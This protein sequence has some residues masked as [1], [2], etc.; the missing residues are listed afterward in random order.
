MFFDPISS[1]LAIGFLAAMYFLVRRSH[2]YWDR[3]GVKSV[4]PVFLLGNFKDNICQRK[5][6]SE[7]AADI[8]KNSTEPL[9]GVYTL[10]R[11]AVVLC[12]PELIRNVFSKDFKHFYHRGFH[13]DENVDPSALN[14]LVSN[15][16]RWKVLREKLSPTFA[17]GKLKGMFDVIAGCGSS[18]LFYVDEYADIDKPIEIREAFARYAT[19]IIASV[20]FGIDID[21]FQTKDAEF[22]ATGSR[23]F[24]TNWRNTMRQMVTTHSPRLSML[25]GIRFMDHEVQE[26]MK[27]IVSRNLEFRD[28]NNF[29]RKDFFQLLTN[30]Y[31]YGAVR[32]DDE[33]K[34]IKSAVDESSKPFSLDE[35]T[36][37]AVFVFAASFETTSST[38]SHC[39]YELSLHA[40][41]Q[42]KLHEEIDAAGDC[43]YESIENMKYLDC[44]VNGRHI[45]M[46]G[47]WPVF[48]DNLSV[49]LSR[50]ITKISASFGVDEGM[51]GGL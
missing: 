41:I 6:F 5:S 30:L 17:T 34:P 37:Q 48:F 31:R 43:S 38:M 26:F 20:A 13:F 12:D 36:A 9:I 33:W 16:E 50:D 24:E 23:I 42:R 49:L 22:R 47:A 25:L 4:R 15:G 44:C 18:L 3:K 11:P 19:N 27:N 1:A 45:I 2:T 46:I 7:I 35:V 21:C 39:L 10:L 8:Y 28:R 32:L 51:Y 40:D 29:F 14:L